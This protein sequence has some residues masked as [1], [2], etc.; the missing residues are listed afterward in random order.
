V[1]RTSG[2]ASTGNYL[3]DASGAITL[4]LPAS[5]VLGDEVVIT[6]ISGNASTN[7]ITVARNSQPIQGVA[8]DLVIDVSNAT[9]RLVYSNTTRGWRL[10]A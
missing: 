5:P 6:D 3:V 4:T 9:I 8:E 10:I 7:N 1:A 2:A